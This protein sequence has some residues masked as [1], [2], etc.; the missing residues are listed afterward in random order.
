M[1]F[2]SRTGSPFV[3]GVLQSTLTKFNVHM[4]P[5]SPISVFQA[6]L[7]PFVFSYMYVVM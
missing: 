7:M 6:A 5:K 1:A 3:R 4:G 2:M